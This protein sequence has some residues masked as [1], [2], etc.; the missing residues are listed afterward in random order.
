MTLSKVLEALRDW[1]DTFAR[2][3]AHSTNVE[4]MVEWEA[5]LEWVRRRID[6]KERRMLD[7]RI[8]GHTDEYIA[9]ATRAT[10]GTVRRFI[11][12]LASSLEALTTDPAAR[13]EFE[14]IHRA[15]MP[16]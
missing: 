10:L 6:E 7:L 3:A 12:S 8:R 1:P 16:R 4:M 11:V 2:C 15:F 5:M 13:A 14:E 9:L